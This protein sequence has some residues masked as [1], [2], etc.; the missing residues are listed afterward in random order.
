VCEERYALS[1]ADAAGAFKAEY[2]TWCAPDA[3]NWP[4]V[5]AGGFAAVKLDLTPKA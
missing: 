1:G 2:D 5:E 3:P 4:L